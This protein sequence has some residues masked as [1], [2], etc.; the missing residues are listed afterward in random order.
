[1]TKGRSWT[2]E[3]MQRLRQL[4]KENKTIDEI[5][6]AMGKTR[7]AIKSKMF[8]LGLKIIKPNLPGLESQKLAYAEMPTELPSVEEALKE[9][10]AAMKALKTPGLSRNEILRLRTIVSTA[11]IY[12]AL[13]AE[14][15]DYRGI[16]KN[17]IEL[18]KKYSD[19]M[20]D[21][22]QKIGEL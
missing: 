22:K 18:E 16:E 21:K 2:F 5:C 12:Q 9:L 1:L 8:D 19:L 6:E 13:V 4:L 15:I 11:K 7:D 20:R 3:E 17:L 14:Y 10:T